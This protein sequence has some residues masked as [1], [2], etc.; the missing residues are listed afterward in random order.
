VTRKMLI[1]L[2]AL[3]AL[4]APLWALPQPVKIHSGLV[5]GVE[6]REPG[7]LVFKGLPYA[8]PPVGN[9]RWR[10]PQPVAPWQGVKRANQFSASCMQTILNAR[11][12]W[13]YEVTTHT[14]I[15][16]DCLYVN[17]WTAAKSASE[18]RPV[19]VFIHG[20]GGTE[21]SGAVPV[22]DGEGLAK[23][24]LVVININYRL[25]ILAG[26]GHPELAQEPGY[27]SSNFAQQDQ[28]AALKWVREN[29]SSFGGDPNCV[30][31][32]GQSAG[33]GAV[34]GLIAS[35]THLWTTPRGGV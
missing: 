31:I 28:T 8:A 21:G 13:T 7:I 12:P 25:G 20:G 32:A 11:A 6:G 3:L 5:S 26:S 33:A 35:H 16:E 9:L 27:V 19:L 4:A 34:H 15:S 29:I 1:V 18:K 10:P 23:K 14:E 22:Y 24:G 2:S 30:T 17:V